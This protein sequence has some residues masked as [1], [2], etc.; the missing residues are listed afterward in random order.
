MTWPFSE[1]SHGEHVLVLNCSSALWEMVSAAIALAFVPLLLT[2]II[3]YRFYFVLFYRAVLLRWVQ[4]FMTGIS[5]EERVYEYVLTNATPGDPE[6]ILNTFDL[7]CSKVEFISHIGPKKGIDHTHTHTDTQ[8]KE[9]NFLPC[10]R[11]DSGPSA[12]G[13]LPFD[14]VGA[15]DPLRLHHGENRSLTASRGSALLGGDGRKERTCG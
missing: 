3:R 8:C 2:L 1:C 4:D 9:V 10:F 7:W 15:G 5:R 6:S 12:E 14:G 11:F 13:D